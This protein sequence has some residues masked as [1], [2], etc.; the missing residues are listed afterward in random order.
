MLPCSPLC[1]C[2]IP[3]PP[4][5]KGNMHHSVTAFTPHAGEQEGAGQLH[6]HFDELGLQQVQT[7]RQTT[8]SESHSPSSLAEVQ[9]HTATSS[10]LDI[11]LTIQTFCTVINK[12]PK[13]Y[14]E[15]LPQKQMVYFY[16]EERVLILYN[17]RKESSSILHKDCFHK[18]YM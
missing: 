2:T 5:H 14:P 9:Q 16:L 10:G 12:R 17:F 8:V 6:Q 1:L 13:N 3:M 18:L 11:R 4:S 15:Y 7:K